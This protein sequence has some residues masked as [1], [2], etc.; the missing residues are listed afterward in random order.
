MVA[1]ALPIWEE[2]EIKIKRKIMNWIR[3]KS[4]IKIKKAGPGHR[5]HG[6]SFS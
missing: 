3:S 4:E 6:C 1:V 5:H 2:A